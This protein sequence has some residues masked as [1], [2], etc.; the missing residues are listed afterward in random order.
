L[1]PLGGRTRSERA[2]LVR[3][4]TVLERGGKC[5]V[6]RLWNDSHTALTVLVA[7]PD[8]TYQGKP[9]KEISVARV[10]YGTGATLTGSHRHLAREFG[11]SKTQVWRDLQAAV[12]R[13][14]NDHA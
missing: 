6:V 14:K 2:A 4:A 9:I 3:A 7:R 10:P 8:A 11:I 13:E 12:K 1:I 5:V